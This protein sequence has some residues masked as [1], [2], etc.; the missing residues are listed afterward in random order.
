MITL[1]VLWNLIEFKDW[2]NK[3][4]GPLAHAVVLTLFL[5]FILTFLLLNIHVFCIVKSRF[6]WSGLRYGTVL[7]SH[8]VK[9]PQSKILFI[10]AHSEVCIVMYGY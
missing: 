8:H 1:I 7:P 10:R 3:E 2:V 6:H 9:V 4:E 5:L